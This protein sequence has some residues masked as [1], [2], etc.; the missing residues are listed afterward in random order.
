MS[1]AGLG[2]GKGGSMDL[3]EKD[4]GAEGKVKVVV[5]K[6]KLSLVCSYDGKGL[7]G[8][9]KMSVDSDYFIDALAAKIPGQIDDMIAGLLK[10][11][12]KAL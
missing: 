4:L 5:E 7:D 11:A 9:V 8:E 10:Q 2:S 3:L 6:G 1:F 12:L